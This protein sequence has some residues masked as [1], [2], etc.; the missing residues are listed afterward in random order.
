MR[1]LLDVFKIV[2]SDIYLKILDYN[3]MTDFDEKIFL[4]NVEI[5][6]F[7]ELR[8]LFENLKYV[9]MSNEDIDKYTLAYKKFYDE[10]VRSKKE[11]MNYQR[12]LGMKGMTGPMPTR[13]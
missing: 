6:S 4:E 9:G 7:T 13:H 3:K 1:M 5:M 12:F 10:R 11:L 8:E 2:I